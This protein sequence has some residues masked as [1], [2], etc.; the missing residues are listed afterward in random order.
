MHVLTPTV[1]DIL[2]EKLTKTAAP[3]RKKTT[4]ADA[5]AELAKREQYLAL[6]KSDWRY[7][8]GVKYGLLNAQL[9]LSL[10]GDDRDEVLSTLLA[11][12]TEREMGQRGR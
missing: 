12:L 7:D 8:V 1:M 3:Q 10:D 2:K 5:L 11:M 9:A 6:E 4:L